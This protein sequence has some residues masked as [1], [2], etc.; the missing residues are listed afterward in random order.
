MNKTEIIHAL[1]EKHR[2]FIEYTNS[3]TDKQLL[4]AKQDKWTAAQQVAHIYQSVKPLA[5]GLVLPKFIVKMIWGKAN[6]SSK[7]YTELVEKYITKLAAG[8]R[9]TAPFVPSPITVEQLPQCYKKIT[10]AIHKLSKHL[11]KYA[12]TDWDVYI[13]PHPLLGKV[14]LREMLYF[15][16]YHVQHHQQIIQRDLE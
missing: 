7:S 6:R 15:T 5:Q 11:H 9:A 4:F 12:E 1:E 2:Y 8:G 10:N 14:T 3:L 16:I 13:L